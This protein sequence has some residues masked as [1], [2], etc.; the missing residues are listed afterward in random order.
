MWFPPWWIGRWG[1]PGV[2]P[3]LEEGIGQLFL[4]TKDGLEGYWVGVTKPD[5]FTYLLTNEVLNDQGKE[6]NGGVI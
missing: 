1:G 4:A 2:V 6:W 5:L 3:A